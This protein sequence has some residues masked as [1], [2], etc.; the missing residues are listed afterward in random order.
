ME[1]VLLSCTCIS[2]R[3]DLWSCQISV[4]IC[5][6]LQKLDILPLYLCNAK[7]L[8]ANPDNVTEWSV[9]NSTLTIPL[10]L[11][12][13]GNAVNAATETESLGVW[14]L[15]VYVTVSPEEVYA[16]K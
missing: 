7:N 9:V 4:I 3:F 10:A 14:S 5:I 1:D 2:Q 15:P 6:V 16:E 8:S 13:V 12:T 11:C